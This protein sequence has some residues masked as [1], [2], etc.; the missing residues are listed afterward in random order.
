MRIWNGYFVIRGWMRRVVRWR[1]QRLFW[2]WKG[3]VVVVVV[4]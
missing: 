4:E 3:L 2:R 1:F